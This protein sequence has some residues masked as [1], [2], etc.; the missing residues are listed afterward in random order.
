MTEPNTTTEPDPDGVD[1]QV[2]WPARPAA[3]GHVPSLDPAVSAL[4]D[5]LGD[6]PDLP[7]A[8]HGDVYASLH[9]ELLAALN[10]TVADQAPG[11][12]TT[13]GTGTET[14]DATHDQA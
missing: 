13:A 14:G 1:A 3:A 4:L 5:R 6:L 12:D 11:R 10:E 8:R 9:D 2:R 7:V